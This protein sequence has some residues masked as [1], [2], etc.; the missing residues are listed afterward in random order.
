MSTAQRSRS[1]LAGRSI[2][3]VVTAR[4]KELAVGDTVA[5]ARRLFDNPSVQVVPVLDGCRY[6]G[7]IDRSAVPSRISD[8]APIEPLVENLLPT[9]RA[10]TPA[11]AAL[12]ALDASGANRMVVLDDDEAYVGLVCLR[13]DRRRLCVDAERRARLTPPTE[14]D[15]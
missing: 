5:A 1:E 10:G 14:G 15:I 7:A 6:L 11:P 12:D 2:A 8:Q 13:S 3:D 4:G 9:C